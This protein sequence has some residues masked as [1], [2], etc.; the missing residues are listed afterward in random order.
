MASVQMTRCH[1]LFT[2]EVS[3]VK[4]L[5]VPS[6][7]AGCAFKQP[8]SLHGVTAYNCMKK[9]QEDCSPLEMLGVCSLVLIFVL[10]IRSEVLFFF[11]GLYMYVM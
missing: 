5:R 4:V 1:M 9:L 11:L 3:I 10:E 8:M 6:Y 7:T 2:P